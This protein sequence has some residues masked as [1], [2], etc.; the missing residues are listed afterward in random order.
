MERIVHHLMGAKVAFQKWR[1][2][3]SVDFELADLLEALHLRTGVDGDK[4]LA[5]L[6]M[7]DGVHNLAEDQSQFARVRAFLRTTVA[8]EQ[9][10]NKWFV[11]PVCSFTARKYA[12]DALAHSGTTKVFLD[13]PGLEHVPATLTEVPAGLFAL[14][15]RHPRA[16]EF[17]VECLHANTAAHFPSVVASLCDKLRQQYEVSV[18]ADDQRKLL[19][20]A[21]RGT[22]VDPQDEYLARFLI[23]GLIHIREERLELS[24]LWILCNRATEGG[25]LESYAWNEERNDR[26]FELF[27]LWFRRTMTELYEDN[28]ALTPDSLYRGVRWLNEPPAVRVTNTVLQCRYAAERSGYAQLCNG[29]PV[30]CRTRDDPSAA[31]VTENPE[32]L[33]NIIFKTVD[34]GPSP[35]IFL[36]LSDNIIEAIQVKHLTTQPIP[37]GQDTFLKFFRPEVKKSFEGTVLTPAN[38]VFIF[39]TIGT[40]PTNWLTWCSTDKAIVYTKPGRDENGKV[41]HTEHEVF[42]RDCMI[43]VIDKTNFADH[44]NVFADFWLNERA[45]KKKKNAKNKEQTAT[46]KKAYLTIKDMQLLLKKFF[47]DEL[48]KVETEGFNPKRRAEWEELYNKVYNEDA[49]VPDASYTD[50]SL[51]KSDV[52]RA[53]K[54]KN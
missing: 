26:S 13:P 28:A 29:E 35:D 38:V 25:L 10:G 19:G 44:Y 53:K 21:L 30:V 12:I 16:L 3:H 48:Y 32:G 42:M 49:D 40:M 18:P 43:G 33:K 14:V 22:R 2:T 1:V 15:R 46:E 17:L 54:P 34:K 39:V 41:T 9:N 51:D 7:L 24:P 6:L 11:F 52:N 20:I 5:C 47:G 45:K 8:T 37:V 36:R 31:T 23:R 27:V 50:S 4:T